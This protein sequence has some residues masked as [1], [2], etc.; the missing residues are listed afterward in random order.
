MHDQ[1]IFLQF[2]SVSI[3]SQSLWQSSASHLITALS[4]MPLNRAQ[5]RKRFR[6]LALR[7]HYPSRF[8]TEPAG[9]E[10]HV[11][12]ELNV[13]VEDVPAVSV[14]DNAGSLPTTPVISDANSVDVE[15]VPAVSV[16][17]NAGSLP[18]T[19]VISDAN[20]VAVEYVP[21]VSVADNAGSLPTTPV[22]SDA[23]SVVMYVLVYC[24]RHLVMSVWALYCASV[25]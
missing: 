18:T 10:V 4:I 12:S 25:R 16:A 5:K 24:A 6:E 23:N 15:Y 20:S 3:C 1:S 21:A 9:A 8:S 7:R 11:N 14:A 2:S 17:D 13:A 22:I 19:P